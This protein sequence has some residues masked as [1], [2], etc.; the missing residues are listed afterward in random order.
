MLEGVLT[1][2]HSWW[3]GQSSCHNGSSALSSSSCCLWDLWLEVG[4]TLECLRTKE[5]IPSWCASNRFQRRLPTH[6]FTSFNIHFYCYI[7]GNKQCFCVIPFISLCYHLILWIG[8]EMLE[9]DTGKQ[10]LRYHLCYFICSSFGGQIYVCLICFKKNK[11]N[12]NLMRRIGCAQKSF[13]AL[14]HNNA[15]VV[16]VYI[17]DF[18]KMFRLCHTNQCNCHHFWKYVTN[19]LF[20][21]Q[22][23][24]VYVS[25]LP[26]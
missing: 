21:C 1:C 17:N 13:L 24:L 23:T 4:G 18:R 3:P 15:T 2:T 22:G 25:L 12:P 10:Q 11:K 5:T 26:W 8:K 9:S 20:W 16:S 6:N 19:K 14:L 7:N